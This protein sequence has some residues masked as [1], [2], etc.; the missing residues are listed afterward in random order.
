MAHRLLSSG[1]E[2]RNL[3]EERVRGFSMGMTSFSLPNRRRS[4]MRTPA[5]AVRYVLITALSAVLTTVLPATQA[6]PEA[7]IGG[8]FGASISSLAKGLT[9][10]EFTEFSPPATISDRELQSSLVGG[11]KVGYY[12]SRA[13]WFGLETEAFYT[14][15]HI[16]QQHTTITIQPGTFNGTPVPGGTAAG[17]LSGDH[18][19]VLTWAPVNFMFRYHRTRLQPYIGVGPGV[20]FGRIHQTTQGFEGS[21]SSTRVGLNAKVGLDYF[22]TRHVSVFGEWKYNLVQFRFAASDTQLAY[23]TTYQMHMAVV[24]LSYHF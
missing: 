14:T 9:N 17:E 15:P 21:Q 7:Y 23:S 11:L 3:F 10:G 5:T 6:Y 8:Q 2:M 13:R 24:G 12:F 22:I 18:F 19:R 20:F 16:K 4:T 1:E